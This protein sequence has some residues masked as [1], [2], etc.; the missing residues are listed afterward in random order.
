MLAANGA[1]S[2]YEV[3]MVRVSII[4]GIPAPEAAADADEKTV[5]DAAEDV[6]TAHFDYFF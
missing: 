6:D 1:Q 5:A 4:G 3:T 2:W